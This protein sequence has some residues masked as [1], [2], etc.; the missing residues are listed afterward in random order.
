MASASEERENVVTRGGD[1]LGRPA[2]AAQRRRWP[3][4]MS[5]KGYERRAVFR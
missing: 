5:Y 3:P 2:A 4:Q 1:F